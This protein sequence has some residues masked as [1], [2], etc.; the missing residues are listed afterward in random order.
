[1]YSAATPVERI[2]SDGCGP[3]TVFYDVV[4]DLVEM[5]ECGCGVGAFDY[6]A[7]FVEGGITLVGLF[8]DEGNSVLELFGKRGLDERIGWGVA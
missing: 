1:M 6:L 4:D 7:V 5:A 3:L 2:R 8:V